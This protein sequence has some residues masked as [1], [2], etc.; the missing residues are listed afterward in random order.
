M[1][2]KLIAQQDM[3]EVTLM[4]NVVVKRF[5][6]HSDDANDKGNDAESHFRAEQNALQ[7][8]QEKFGINK[9]KGWTYRTVQLLGVGP[10][11]ES[12]YL[13]YLEAPTIA[14]LCKN[15]MGLA[16]YHAGVWLALYHQKMILSKCK[17]MLYTD[18]TVYNIHVDVKNQA[19]IAI[20]PGI[21]WGRHGFFYEDVI[22]HIHSILFFSLKK[23]QSPL[24]LV[25]QFLKGYVAPN[26]PH[27]LLS[28]YKGLVRELKRLDWERGRRVK[29][30][31]SNFYVY[32]FKRS[33][34]RVFSMTLFPFFVAYLP[35][36][37]AWQLAMTHHVRK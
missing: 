19:V 18:Y 4:G 27:C 6:Q 16:E 32:V 15:D 35:A 10:E 9:F 21:Y 11:G 22:L 29:K 31:T 25:H 12:L 33:A 3:C 17:T 36:Y 23:K 26:T 34:Y 28:Y 30:S 7:V 8:L 5:L 37:V 13:E 14:N 1:E 24:W 2:S 20:D